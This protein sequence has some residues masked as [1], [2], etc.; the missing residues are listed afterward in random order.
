MLINIILH[1]SD[2]ADY[3]R[4]KDEGSPTGESLP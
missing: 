2:D 1:R 3:V 4:T